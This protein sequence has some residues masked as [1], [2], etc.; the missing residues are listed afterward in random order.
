ME[1]QRAEEANMQAG[2]ELD[3]AEL[4]SF[5]G[6]LSGLEGVASAPALE[7]ELKLAARKAQ[8]ARVVWEDS[9]RRV[10]S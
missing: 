2:L 6:E 9:V 5:Q 8:Q 3:K 10:R 1:R 4:I 7:A